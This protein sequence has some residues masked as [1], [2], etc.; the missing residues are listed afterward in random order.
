[1]IDM[2]Y[3]FITTRR[4]KQRRLFMKKVIW[5]A[6]ASLV[7][8]LFVSIT[9]AQTSENKSHVYPKPVASIPA[10]SLNRSD[11]EKPIAGSL[12]DVVQP[13]SAVDADL[14]DRVRRKVVA[15]RNLSS[16]AA[17]I[18]IVARNGDVHL[19][20]LIQNEGEKAQIASKAAA[21]AGTRHVVNDLRVMPNVVDGSGLRE[22]L[23]RA[24]EPG[25]AVIAAN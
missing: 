19:S 24:S 5:M 13:E 18:S 12:T 6:P 3:C 25:P 16:Y 23:Q 20:G 17:K 8:V 1:M 15:D 11:P 21:V 14:A 10:Q 9:A 4:P 22:F 7:A 2:A